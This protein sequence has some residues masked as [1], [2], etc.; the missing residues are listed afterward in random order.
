MT[1][2]LLMVPRSGFESRCNPSG[3]LGAGPATLVS[4]WA[5]EVLGP[6]LRSLEHFEKALWSLMTC[7]VE[8]DDCEVSG[9]PVLAKPTPLFCSAAIRRSWNLWLLLQRP[10]TF[11]LTGVNHN[12][13]NHMGGGKKLIKTCTGKNQFFLHQIYVWWHFSLATAISC[14]FS[15]QATNLL[16]IALLPREEANEDIAL[17]EDLLKTTKASAGLRVHESLFVHIYVKQ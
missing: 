4:R 12:T 8:F 2:G 1:L 7:A 14:V 11:L 9:L 13:V 15:N 16:T 5:V 10:P 3:F 6:V 17:A